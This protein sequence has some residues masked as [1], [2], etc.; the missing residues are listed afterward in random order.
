[1]ATPKLREFGRSSAAM[2]SFFIDEFR[3]RISES[4]SDGVEPSDL[5]SSLPGY[6]FDIVANGI[7]MGFYDVRTR[8]KEIF[9][10]VAKFAD[11]VYL[12]AVTSK[13]DAFY[14]K[15][16]V[17]DVL[18]AMKE[19][20]IISHAV[21]RTGLGY[22][23]LTIS[24]NMRMF[25]DNV[26]YLIDYPVDIVVKE[27]YSGKKLISCK[28]DMSERNPFSDI[29]STFISGTSQTIN[30]QQ[31]YVI[32]VRAHQIARNVQEITVTPNSK[33]SDIYSFAFE[34]QL[35]GI[36]VSYRQTDNDA[37]ENLELI[38]NGILLATSSKKFCYYRLSDRTFEI[39]FSANP[40]HFSPAFNSR[41]KIEFF[42]T[43]GSAG[44]FEYTLGQVKFQYDQDRSDV[45]QDAFVNV[46]SFG[47][48]LSSAS[49]H[50]E[51][52]PS[53]D[54]LR[55]LTVT[56]KS[57]RNTII[58]EPDILRIM[59][60]YGMDVV[61]IQDD[62]FDRVF[63]TYSIIRDAASKYVVPSRTSQVW[64][65]QRKLVDQQEIN[66]FL[67][68]T[69]YVYQKWLSE[70]LT[71]INNTR[72]EVK[73]EDENGLN[74]SIALRNKNWSHL[75][76][77][78]KN[79]SGLLMMCP[80]LLKI[81]K[82]PYLVTVFDVQCD[83]HI[84]TVFGYNNTMSPEKFAINMINVVRTDIR[85][86]EYFVYCDVIVSQVILDEFD[87]MT[88]GSFPVN[89]KLEIL[90]SNDNTYAYMTLDTI[91]K[92]PTGKLRFST[93]LETDDVL[94]PDGK[95]R[96]TSG[97]IVPTT[98]SMYKESGIIPDRYF[99]PFN[100]KMKA[101]I[102]YK[103]ATTF[104]NEHAQYM[105]TLYEE[106]N[107]FVI[108]DVFETQERMFFVRDV[109]DMFSITLEA[110][111]TD[112][113][114][115]KYTSDVP[116]RYDTIMYEK[117]ADGGIV[118]DSQGN[119]VVLHDIGDIVYESD[120][121][122]PVYKFRVGDSMIKRNE[123]G[124]YIYETPPEVTFVMHGVP[125]ILMTAMLDPER[126]AVIYSSLKKVSDTL[127]KQVL[128]KLVEN[129]SVVIGLYNTVGPSGTFVI[130]TKGN[131]V[132][133]DN[134]DIAIEL[135]V[136]FKTGDNSDVLKYSISQSVS[137]YIQT[138]ANK[139]VLYMS[140]ILTYIK[141]KY[142]DIDYIEFVSLN[143][144]DTK[145]QTINTA[146]LESTIR[147]NE[148]IPEYVTINQLLDEQAFKHDGT[149]KLSPNIIINVI[150]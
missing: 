8:S 87:N 31:W 124:S 102:A 138:A 121:V 80:Y 18:I 76:N 40:N 106:L 119:P 55:E 142:S 26:Y 77:V 78:Y 9:P 116:M 126:R 19:R 58:S 130:G 56:A 59:A 103:P 147:K 36:R 135:N 88:A 17:I 46:E 137:E 83:S 7:E 120:G 123:D 81:I 149:V 51:D 25:L 95:L 43:D 34:R 99:I 96:I 136:R 127:Y 52:K 66:S 84:G 67:I 98:E 92:L 115:P 1:M 41:V 112:G 105:L 139:G 28:Y 64:I 47:Q 108:T 118:Y 69:D 79:N 134:I 94:N 39:S 89:V 100:G 2:K 125:L 143:G 16:A 144:M 63:R 33:T 133:M 32:K 146:E 48:L 22:G 101:Y 90:D 4:R 10:T 45:Y 27:G 65:P 14:A 60:P 50:G 117:D 72:F 131:Y 75:Y 110:I 129:N 29:E 38:Y 24:K 11:N 42:I 23:M 107:G 54:K 21:T 128:P 104:P 93:I 57:S 61:K 148:I 12:H 30:N 132:P 150:I 70:D 20:D 114:F 68:P 86:R 3:Q 145:F 49:E 35:A 122:T 74:A 91:E 71:G 5:H 140:D 73:D 62:I 82:D 44:N 109:T 15:P 13:I 37:W 97:N 6:L 111:L 53:L 85:N 113:V 141:G